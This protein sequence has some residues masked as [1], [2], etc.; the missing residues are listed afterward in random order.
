MRISSL[1]FLSGYLLTT[2]DAKFVPP[3]PFQTSTKVMTSTINGRKLPPVT[4][5][6]TIPLAGSLQHIYGSVQGLA[7]PV[8]YR[9]SLETSTWRFVTRNERNCPV[10]VKDNKKF[11]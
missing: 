5:T 7:N 11:S 6:M 4:M 10:I 9:V 1:L 8:D 2:S 3:A